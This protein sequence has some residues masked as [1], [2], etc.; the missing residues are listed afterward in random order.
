VK[1]DHRFLRQPKG[2]TWGGYRKARFQIGFDQETAA[3]I[4]ELAK[5]HDRSFT[6]EVR[7]LVDQALREPPVD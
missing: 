1:G 7:A 6:A 4:A 2:S 3:R 5:A